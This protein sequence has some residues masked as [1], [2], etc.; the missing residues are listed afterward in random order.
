M[1]DKP[2]ARRT[3]YCM[4][5][6][7][8]ILDTLRNLIAIPSGYPP[9]DSTAI[10][11]YAANRLE[12]AGYDV[13]VLSRK[14]PIDN[15]IARL[16]SGKPSIVFNAHV[17]TVAVAD[18][19]EWN[20]DPFE[21]TLVDGRVHGLGAGN[22][23]GSMAVQIWL[24]EEIA[25]RGGPA[26]GEVVFTFV[27]DEETLGPDGLTY[28]RDTNAIAPDVLICGAQTQ[29]QA[30]TE[31]RGVIWIEITTSGTSA[32]AGEPQN[33][34]NAIDR[35][36]RIINSLNN[37]LQPKLKDRTRGALR[38][39]M[40]IGIVDGGTNTNAVPSACRI[41]I[42]RRLLPEETIAGAVA[43]IEAIVASAGEP[44]GTWA[45]N[46]LTGSQGF[47]SPP[48]SPS[49]MAFHTA[50]EQITGAAHREV[51]AI[52][53]SDARYFADDGLVLMTFGPG[54]AKDGHKANEFVPLDELEPAARIQLSVIEEILGFAG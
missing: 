33:G 43:E 35:M 46:L 6:S 45:V 16:G 4:S 50:I 2:L 21:A 26:K 7:D 24:A 48:D 18:R 38:S 28:L 11:A 41:E 23:K 34:D 8:E 42:D 25:R 19:T 22:C 29:L 1:L 32:H 13:S 17:D 52:G 53:A 3:D 30:I 37:N 20:T 54:H 51:V 14:P 40:S 5:T 10:C 39:T 36:V 49:I 47:A 27:G 31:E 15:V 12:A 44:A 9:G